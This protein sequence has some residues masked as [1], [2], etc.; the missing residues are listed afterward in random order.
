MSQNN[1]IV[2]N[3]KTIN[4]KLIELE[5]QISVYDISANNNG[6]VY[7]SLSEAL[8]DVPND[9]KK[10]GMTIKFIRNYPA[11]FR[12]TTN[13]VNNE[14]DDFTEIQEIISNYPEL[15][16]SGFVDNS[17]R[18]LKQ[19]LYD[20]NNIH[21]T[22][23]EEEASLQ[24]I[25]QEYGVPDYPDVRPF[26]KL[27]IDNTEEYFIYNFKLYK[28]PSQKYEQWYLPFTEYWDRDGTLMNKIEEIER[29]RWQKIDFSFSNEKFTLSLSG[30]ELYNYSGYD[31]EVE[32]EIL[33]YFYENMPGSFYP[34]WSKMGFVIAAE[35]T[36]ENTADITMRAPINQGNT[37]E[38]SF[39]E[40][41]TSVDIMTNSETGDSELVIGEFPNNPEGPNPTN[42]QKDDFKKLLENMDSELM[43]KMIGEPEVVG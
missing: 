14:D 24:E 13:Y 28:V 23:P 40:I 30:G 35:A 18:P 10:G 25:L 2:C 34:I 27:Y 9:Q 1:N 26:F 39:F 8:A 11:V 37:Q 7:N 33:S 41:M 43:K 22:N 12:V 16:Y 17:N 4:D 32:E 6:K 36:S 20:W 38:N 3:F 31:E 21:S 5:N 29:N 15:V 19:G 42:K